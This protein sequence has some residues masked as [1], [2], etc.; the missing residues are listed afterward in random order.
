[1]SKAIKL[2]LLIALVAAILWLYASGAYGAVPAE[3]LQTWI[4][5]A[6]A[7]GGVVFVAGMHR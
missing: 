4:R 3:A 2:G 5:S 7:W 6:G 1:M